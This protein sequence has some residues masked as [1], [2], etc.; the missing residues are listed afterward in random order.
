MHRQLLLL[1]K[2]ESIE[3]LE[4]TDISDMENGVSAKL[5]GSEVA[6][7]RAELSQV[8]GK[9]EEDLQSAL[10]LGHGASL[11]LKDERLWH[12]SPSFMT[13]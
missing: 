4:L 1:H 7:V 5:K 2:D 3:P 13:I 9:L 12:Y 10:N 8:S 6:F 11:L